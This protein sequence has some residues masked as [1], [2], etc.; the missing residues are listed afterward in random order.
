MKNTQM[1]I[2]NEIIG[3]RV[4]DETGA[5]YTVKGYKNLHQVYIILEDTLGNE[6]LVNLD[7][8]DNMISI[9]REVNWDD[10]AP[11]PYTITAGVYHLR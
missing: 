7:R 3:S 10:V 5:K 11:V 9:D 1:D 8:Y 4:Q 6:T 2:L